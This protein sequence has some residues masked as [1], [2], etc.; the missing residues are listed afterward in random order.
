MSQDVGKLRCRIAQV[1][2]YYWNL[3]SKIRQSMNE[4]WHLCEKD[5]CKFIFPLNKY[6]LCGPFDS[7]KNK[8]N[9]GLSKSDRQP[10]TLDITRRGILFA[11]TSM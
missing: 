9:I 4:K 1:P 10:V 8:N 5:I 2:L 3:S 6:R 7:K 11:K